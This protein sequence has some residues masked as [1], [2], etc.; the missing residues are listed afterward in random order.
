M[1]KILDWDSFLNLFP[2]KEKTVGRNGYDYI[3]KMKCLFLQSW[4]SIS[5]EELEYQ[6]Y[7]RL[8]FQAFLD[9]PETI[10][11]Y[12]TIWRFRE[13]LTKGN[14][15]EK[16]WIELQRQIKE[17]QI[18]ISKGVIQDATFVKAEPGKKNS[19]MKNRGREAK[20]SRNA[21]GTWTKKGKKSYFGYKLHT[22]LDKRNKIITELAVTTAKT[23]DGHIDLAQP[24]ETIYR[25]KAYSGSPT[26]A[27]GN[28]SMKKG[29]LSI[30]DKLRNKRI[31]K[32]RC[33]GEHHFG[34]IARSFKGG[35]T[36]LTTLT[37][38]YIQ[39]IFVCAAY[40]LHRLR[41]LLNKN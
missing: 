41:F 10:P 34:T 31:S 30:K 22:K 8:D 29:R 9:F 19:G 35:Y 24:D 33:R 1:K 21:D 2:N 16:I 39:Q 37:R 40:N 4:F 20:T 17:K 36:K 5:D 27:K 14:I 12:S 23:F 13:L 3:L 11:D 38:V 26:K 32:Q 25:D 6:I 15:A 7:N 28:A 18:K